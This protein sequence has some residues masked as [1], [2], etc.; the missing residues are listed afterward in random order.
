MINK[1][2]LLYI[3]DMRLILWVASSINAVRH[4]DVRI[5]H[6]QSGTG[7]GYLKLPHLSSNLLQFSTFLSSSRS[8]CCQLTFAKTFHP[9]YLLLSQITF[10]LFEIWDSGGRFMLRSG[11]NYLLR[12]SDELFLFNM[13]LGTSCENYVSWYIYEYI[14]II[15]VD[16]PP[17]LFR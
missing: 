13:R 1:Q 10:Q 2:A 7:W 15:Q 3:S 8:H 6:I 5:W 16:I 12:F 14:N 11:Q 9:T 17:V 4:T